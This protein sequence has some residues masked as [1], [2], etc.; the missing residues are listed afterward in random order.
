MVLNY[1]LN[2]AD[3]RV[4]AAGVQQTTIGRP[5]IHLIIITA[6]RNTS[7]WYIC[8]PHR[9]VAVTSCVDC[10][11]PNSIQPPAPLV[12]NNSRSGDYIVGV[13][14]NATSGSGRDVSAGC[15][16]LKSGTDRYKDKLCFL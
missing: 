9:A 15:H 13:D 11:A 7:Q 2:L 3:S 10:R 8:R 4:A 12:P 14:N 5:S 16:P 1:Y 6:I